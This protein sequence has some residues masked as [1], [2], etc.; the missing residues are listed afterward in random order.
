VAEEST[1]ELD[2]G[3]LRALVPQVLAALLAVD[4]A[5]TGRLL[6]ALTAA[7]I[8]ASLAAGR[9]TD[10]IGARPVAVG[11]VLASLGAVGLL[12][13]AGMSS[14]WSLVLPLAVLGIGVGLASPAAQ[15]AS[16]AAVA[17]EHSGAAA[18]IATT[19]RYLSGVVGVALLGRLVDLAGEPSAVLGEHRTVLAVFAGVLVAAAACAVVLPG[20]AAPARLPDA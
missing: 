16:L 2:E 3:A 14:P 8:V 15:S 7:M 1:R 11:G 4:S 18:G 6:A 12:A 13:A 5:V 17:R 9:L 10:R 20:R 19:M